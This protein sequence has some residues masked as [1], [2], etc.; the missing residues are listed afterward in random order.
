M[1]ISR[2]VLLYLCIAI[3]C[4]FWQPTLVLGN[5]KQAETVLNMFAINTGDFTNLNNFNLDNSNNV[6]SNLISQ[7][8]PNRGATIILTLIDGLSNAMG[9]I[10]LIFRAVISPIIIM[11]SGGFPYQITYMIGLP[12]VAMFIIA[13]VR[14]IRGY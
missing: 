12:L 9:Y 13:I 4:L 7:S 8:I 3:G 11:V 6:S 5:S 14:F 2:A 1:D 10:I